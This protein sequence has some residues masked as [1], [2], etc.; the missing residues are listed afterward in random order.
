MFAL[1]F[2]L[3]RSQVDFPQRFTGHT[4]TSGAELVLDGQLRVVNPLVQVCKTNPIA[5]G[6]IISLAVV[7][8]CKSS[9]GVVYTSIHVEAAP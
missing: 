5:A 2:V 8:P 4:L 6:V 3:C 7:T 1:I 9:Y